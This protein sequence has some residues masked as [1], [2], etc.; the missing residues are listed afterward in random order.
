MLMLTDGGEGVEQ[1]GDVG[2]LE[3]YVTQNY[4]GR[5]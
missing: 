4:G 2:G 5:A 3:P 1:A